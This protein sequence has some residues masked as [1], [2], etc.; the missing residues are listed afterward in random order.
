MVVDFL[1][2]TLS[3]C[4]AVGALNT[5]LPS[6]FTPN[7]GRKLGQ[8]GCEVAAGQRRALWCVGRKTC[9]QEFR[10]C[11][12]SQVYEGTWSCGADAARPCWRWTGL[13]SSHVGGIGLRLFRWP[14]CF[15]F[16]LLCLS[17][18]S[19]LQRPIN[20]SPGAAA[21]VHGLGPGSIWGTDPK[22][23]PFAVRCVVVRVCC[24]CGAY[25]VLYAALDATVVGW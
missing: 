23:V 10:V 16:F 2:W 13:L 25:S 3:R 9:T 22:L 17:I 1:A 7:S 11:L 8:A 18:N 5:P 24:E 4:C 21:G 15:F 14:R 12:R 19:F 6:L 20:H